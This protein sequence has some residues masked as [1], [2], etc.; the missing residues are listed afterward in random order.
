MKQDLVKDVR[1]RDFSKKIEG[2]RV[3]QIVRVERN[4]NVFISFPENQH[5]PLL[6]RFVSSLKIDLLKQAALSGQQ[7]L[8]IFEKGDPQ[9]P[10]IIDTLYSFIDEM[11]DAPELDLQADEAQNVTIDGKQIS[12]NAKEQIVLRCGRSS[13]TLTKA[14]KVLIRGAYLLSRS[15]GANRIKGGS[16]QIN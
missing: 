6:A 10:I 1:L 11:I 9:L 4:G 14:G 13:I 12:F 16:V 2:A 5:E 3:G 8:L 7:I 15:S